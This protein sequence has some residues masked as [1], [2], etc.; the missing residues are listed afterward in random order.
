VLLHCVA[1]IGILRASDDFGPL[2]VDVAGVPA[3]WG[4]KDPIKHSVE[5]E[6][7]S[8]CYSKGGQILKR[9]PRAVW[10]PIYGDISHSLLQLVHRLDQILSRIASNPNTVVQH[11]TKLV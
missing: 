8:T 10:S 4:E 5:M 1:K 3:P 9:S 2:G 6:G 11:G 7:E